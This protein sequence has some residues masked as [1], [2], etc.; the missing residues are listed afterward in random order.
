MQAATNT[1]IVTSEARLPALHRWWLAAV[2]V[3][4][5]MLRGGF[6]AAPR[7][8]SSAVLQ[9][10]AIVG[11]GRALPKR[12]KWGS[13]GRHLVSIAT[14]LVTVLQMQRMAAFLR[15]WCAEHL[16]G[17]WQIEHTSQICAYRS[18]TMEWRD[19]LRLSAQWHQCSV[20]GAYDLWRS[21]LLGVPACPANQWKFLAQGAPLG[22]LDSTVAERGVSEEYKEI[23]QWDERISVFVEK[24]EMY[25]A[26]RYQ[27][28]EAEWG[29][30]YNADV[31]RQRFID[32]ARRSSHFDLND[33]QYDLRGFQQEM[34]SVQWN[35]QIWWFP[36]LPPVAEAQ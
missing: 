36:H 11:I 25:W 21:D 17:Q 18:N 12:L 2:A 5:R 3:L 16:R 35:D 7:A 9:W 10:L 13:E 30:W 28:S 29:Q 1:A 27:F 26:D 22:A 15:E 19:H 14:Q 6:A 20:Q 33:P 23:L 34:R 31:V 32:A 4:L 24:L 8:A